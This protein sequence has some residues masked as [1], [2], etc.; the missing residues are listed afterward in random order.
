MEMVRRET[1]IELTG[2]AAPGL[3]DVPGRRRQ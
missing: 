1:T 2:S 3:K